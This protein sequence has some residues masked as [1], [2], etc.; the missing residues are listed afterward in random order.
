MQAGRRVRP[1]QWRHVAEA[2]LEMSVNSASTVIPS[3]SHDANALQ[4]AEAAER[5][6]NIHRCGK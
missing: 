4:I 5:L 2:I 3:V 6:I 1:G